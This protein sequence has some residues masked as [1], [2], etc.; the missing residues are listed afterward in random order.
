MHIEDEGEAPQRAHA[1][2]D[3]DDRVDER[4]A[5]GEQAAEDEDQQDERDRQAHGLPLGE[6]LLDEP[7]DGVA[8]ELRG[9]R[10]GIRIGRVLAQRVEIG[11]LGRFGHPV[12]GGLGTVVV[13]ARGERDEFHVA[14]AVGGQQRP[15]LLRGGVGH[16]EGVLHRGDVLETGQGAARRR[17]R[18]GEPRRVGV[19]VDALDDDRHRLAIG[20][21]GVRQR[22]D[23][24]G[25]GVGGRGVRARQP[26]EEPAMPQAL[27]GQAGHGGQQQ[28]PGDDEHHRAPGDGAADICEHGSPRSGRSGSG[29]AHGRASVR[30]PDPQRSI[31][32]C[33][34]NLVRQAASCGSTANPSPG[35]GWAGRRMATGFRLVHAADTGTYKA[36][37]DG[38]RFRRGPRI[39]VGVD[40][41]LQ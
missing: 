9:H 23:L 21:V 36:F 8:D 33:C 24:F 29:R 35:R 7:A 17:H 39:P 1:D 28:R 40:S 38:S 10:V 3:R 14:V 26:L 5:G 2:Q 15:G 18:G 12:V 20:P 16:R 6:V 32:S 13:E 37:S 27:E 31:S 34:Q 19:H 30:V 22:G 25:L 41:G 11:A 4:Q